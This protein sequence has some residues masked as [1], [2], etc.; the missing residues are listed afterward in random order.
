[1]SATDRLREKAQNEQ[2]S[3][4]LNQLLEAQQSHNKKLQAQLAVK[5]LEVM[6]LRVDLCDIK[7]LIGSLSLP[8]KGAIDTCYE[9][10]EKALSTTFTPEHL[11]AWLGEPV[12]WQYEQNLD[13]K[14][15]IVTHL[16]KFRDR[17]LEYID[18]KWTVK[19]LYAPKLEIK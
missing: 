19:P 11:I 6:Q 3:I 12:A 7:E 10:A 16:L 8:V 1:M 4:A 15:N 18:S 13:G 9:I 17:G 2:T 5:D 14:G